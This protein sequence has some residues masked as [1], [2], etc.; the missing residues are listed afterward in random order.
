MLEVVLEIPL[1]IANPLALK[2]AFRTSSKYIGE[3]TGCRSRGRK[4][5]RDRKLLVIVLRMAPRELA[6]IM[7]QSSTPRKIDQED[8]QYNKCMN[9]KTKK[10]FCNGWQ[11]L[12]SSRANS[13][14]S[15]RIRR[16]LPSDGETT[17]LRF[18]H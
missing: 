5:W 18:L 10:A 7:Q 3:N 4:Y 9:S 2:T 11:L 16:I 15:H 13:V 6:K 12:V 1:N 8:D 17:V 14:M